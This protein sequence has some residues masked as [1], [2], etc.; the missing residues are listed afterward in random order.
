MIHG[1][2]ARSPAAIW[3]EGGGVVVNCGEGGGVNR[4]GCGEKKQ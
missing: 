1:R 4:A 3:G 2:S